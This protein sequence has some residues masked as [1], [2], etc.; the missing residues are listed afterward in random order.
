M[1]RIPNHITVAHLREIVRGY[2]QKCIIENA[3]RP[4]AQSITYK[5]LLLT[6]TYNIFITATLYITHSF[7]QGWGGGGIFYM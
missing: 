3:C 6:D 5:P 1:R 7:V 2:Q 4:T